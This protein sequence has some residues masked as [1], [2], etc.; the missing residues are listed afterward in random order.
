MTYPFGSGFVMQYGCWMQPSR[1]LS[2]AR[3]EIHALFPPSMLPEHFVSD[4]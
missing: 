4:F 2:L 1:I 3:N